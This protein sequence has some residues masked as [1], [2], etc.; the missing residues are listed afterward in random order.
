MRIKLNGYQGIGILVS[1]IWF[2]GC[3]G[4]TGYILYNEKQDDVLHGRLAEIRS[5]CEQNVKDPLN[6]DAEFD[7]SILV[8]KRC[9]N[10]ARSNFAKNMLA[11]SFGT[12]FFGWLLAWFGIVISRWIRRASAV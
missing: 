5:L 4:Y 9:F 1:V 3:A 8:R 7:P 10:E 6:P 11:I 12:V 2:I